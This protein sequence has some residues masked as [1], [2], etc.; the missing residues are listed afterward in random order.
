[1]EVL[2]EIKT[3]ERDWADELVYWL[4]GPAGSGKSTIAQT[5]AEHSAADGRLGASFFCS[6]D[7][8]DRR[9]LQL[10]FPTLA[11]ELAYKSA[12]FKSALVQII[13]SNPSPEHFSLAVQ[14]EM[15]LVRPL[16]CEQSRKPEES[17]I[18]IAR[19]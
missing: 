11:H 15:L 5:F 13:S 9:N 4:K 16:K 8:P 3:W 6:R 18:A 14:L 1:M 19:D 12:E 2:Q 7:F 10:I 17:V